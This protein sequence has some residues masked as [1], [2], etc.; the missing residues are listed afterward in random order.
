[1]PHYEQLITNAKVIYS[2]RRS[3]DQ[4]KVIFKF[5]ALSLEQEKLLNRHILHAQRQAIAS[6]Q[7]E[8]ITPHQEKPTSSNEEQSDER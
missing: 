4:Y 6:Q 1:M 3:N 5:C 7:R 2:K 8:L